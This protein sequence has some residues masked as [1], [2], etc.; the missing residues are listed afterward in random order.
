MSGPDVSSPQPVLPVVSVEGDDPPQGVEK[1]HDGA[2]SGRDHEE[3]GG[4]SAKADGARAEA[5]C[6]HIGQ[7]E[8]SGHHAEAQTHHVG[9]DVAVVEH[10]GLLALSQLLQPGVRFPGSNRDGKT[11]ETASSITNICVGQSLPQ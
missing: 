3:V 9:Q 2:V 1:D 6:Q 10:L 4:L 8:G 7:R 5:V 11:W